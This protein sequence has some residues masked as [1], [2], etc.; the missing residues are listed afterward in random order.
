MTRQELIQAVTNATG[1]SKAD[2]EKHLDAIL[3][4]IGNALR[5]GDKISLRG[6]GTFKTVLRQAR[7]A[8]NP[9]TG[10]TILVKETDVVRFKASK[11]L[12]GGD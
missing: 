11:E 6:F 7:E 9:K 4:A 8:R 5:V 1:S 12:L 2:A 10:V 3:A